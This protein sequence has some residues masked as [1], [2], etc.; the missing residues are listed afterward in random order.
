MA[1]FLSVL[2]LSYF[3]VLRA[4]AQIP[5]GLPSKPQPVVFD[6]WWK[7]PLYIGLPIIMV[8]YFIYVNRKKK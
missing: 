5:Q 1:K 7:Y 3:M 2:A 8:V 6:V 4:S